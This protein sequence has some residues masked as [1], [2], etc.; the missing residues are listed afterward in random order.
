MGD[1]HFYFLFCHM[2]AKW[3]AYS[4]LRY[5][6]QALFASDSMLF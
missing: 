2:Q 5:D 1:F 6:N 4:V 3:F